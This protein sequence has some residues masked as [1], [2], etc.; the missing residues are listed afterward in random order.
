MRGS[1]YLVFE[2]LKHDLQGM[3]NMKLDFSMAQIKCIMLQVLHGVAYLHQRHVIHRDIKG[4]NI[5]LSS[6][7]QVKLADFGLAR[8]FYPG[9]ERVHYTNRVVTLWYRA[10]ELLLGARNYNEAVDMWSVGCVFAELVTQQVLFQGD[11]DEK[12]IELIYEKCGSVD[13]ESWPGVKE[14]RAY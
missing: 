11:K 3:I 12:Q 9:D 10:P 4:A 13:S 2:Y 7:G 6:K 1:F 14:L 5:L 8:I